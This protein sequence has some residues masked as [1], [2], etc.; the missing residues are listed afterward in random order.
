MEC[1]MFN[2][3]NWILSGAVLTSP[4]MALD[5]AQVETP[6]V[7]TETA[8]NA[9]VAPA[10]VAPVEAFNRTEALARANASLNAIDT[11][12][13]QFSQLDPN[14]HFST[15]TFYLNRP[16]R[17]RF[18]YD[19]PVPLLIV[20]DGTTLAIEDTDLETVDR[21]PLVSTPLNLILRRNTDLAEHADIISIERKAGYVAIR[22]ADKSGEAEGELELFFDPEDYTLARWEAIDMMGGITTV[23]LNDIELGVSVDPRLFRIEDPEDE[24]DRRR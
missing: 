6:V 7:E 11:A 1:Q 8:A 10:E 4:F 22:V 20:S 9:E 17:L 12:R 18:E 21:V 2:F 15:G 16:G 5:T 14:N 19:A 23:Q 3:A 24:D 13:G